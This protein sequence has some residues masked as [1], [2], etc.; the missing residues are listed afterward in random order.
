MQP[1]VVQADINA[2]INLALRAIADPKLW[3]IHP[4]LRSQR[5]G[6]DKTGKDKKSKVKQKTPKPKND[7]KLLTRE[8]RKFGE[9]GKALV[10]QRP[11][12]AKTD[13]TRQPNFFADLAGL[14]SIASKLAE[15]NPHDYSWLK[16]EWTSATIEGE[17]ST[18]PLL[19]GKSF[20]G[21]VKSYQWERIRKIN[22]DRISTW[23]EKGNP[24]P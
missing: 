16:K 13:D 20:W 11:P 17:S 6:G 10:V 22:G 18:P 7:G 1:A 19:H 12:T 24:M 4:R 3:P 9:T 14:D 5:E 23:K 2:A 21:T 15:K 8:K